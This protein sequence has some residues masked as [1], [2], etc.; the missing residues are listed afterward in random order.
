ML[1]DP[2]VESPSGRGE[3][4]VFSRLMAPSTPASLPHAQEHDRRPSMRS[5]RR[6]ASL[7]SL[8]ALGATLARR[9]PL[10][11]VSM[12]VS[13]LTA[14][15]LSLLAFAFARRGGDAPVQSV[16]ILASS[17]IAWGGGFLQAVAISAGALRRDRIE[18][19]RHLFVSRTTSLHGYLLARV[20][21][22]AAVLA[23]VVGGGTLL[24]SLVAIIGA[25]RVHAVTRTFH[26]TF[27]AV[28]YALAFAAVIAPVVFAA[29]GTRS[30]LSGYLVL[31]L[32]LVLPEALANMLTGPLPS[33]VTEL[34]AIPSALAALRASVAPG[35]VDPFR[36]LRALVAAAIF[37]GVAVF[38]VRR[39][40]LVA[41]SEDT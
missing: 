38:F 35:S 17:A 2:A 26:S 34:C 9:G 24:V 40:L 22:L 19:V 18:G 4:V 21:G 36:F 1:G 5:E 6:R 29:L 14:I 13:V 39:G 25:T 30:R 3:A 28:V 41:E 12:A 15:G 7:V 37:G 20:G 23:A 27:A 32:V 8:L 11:V 31:L 16:P 10:A 33:E